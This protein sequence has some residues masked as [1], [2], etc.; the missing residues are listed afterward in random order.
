MPLCD[1]CSQIGVSCDVNAIKAE[2]GSVQEHGAPAA[3]EVLHEGCV[4]VV[5]VE[6]IERVSACGLP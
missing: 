4:V 6:L 1:S 5:F 3:P 2:M